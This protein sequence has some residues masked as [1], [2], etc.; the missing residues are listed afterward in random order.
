MSFSGTLSQIADITMGQSPNGEDV[1]EKG[2]GIPL[3]NGP[4]EF[5]DF[6]P[7]PVQFTTEGRKFSDPGDILFC[8]RGSTTGKMNYSDRKYAIGRGL[9]AIRGKDNYPT[10]YIRALIER[11]LPDLLQAATGSTF[12]NVG[13]EQLLNL[14][15][16]ILGEIEAQVVGRFLKSLEDKI[17]LNRQTNQTLE[18]IAQA[19]FQFWFVDFDPVHAKKEGRDTGLPPHIADLFP[20]E[21]VESELGM[22]PKGWE[23]RKLR[24]VTEI[25]YGKNLPTSKLLKTG[26]PVFG[27]NGVIGFYDKFLYENPMC[28]VSCRGAASGKVVRSLPESFVTNNSLVIDHE[29]KGILTIYYLEPYLERARLTELVSGSAQPQMTIANM[30]SVQIVIPTL[31]LINEHSKLVEPIYEKILQVRKEINGLELIRD[32]LL[33]KLLSGELQLGDNEV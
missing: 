7:V 26:Y 4:T 24:D 27:G 6:Y 1:N 29:K 17:E 30:D 5:K 10:Q 13:R 11:S 14:N 3:L 9:A 18:Q 16:E 31:N 15:I 28:L 8:V 20:D 25:T 23:V 33:P 19:I 22:I 21:F 2:D 32:S 12:P